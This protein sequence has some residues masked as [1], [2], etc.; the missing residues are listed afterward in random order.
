VKYN[1]NRYGELIQ[2][3]DG[4]VSCTWGLS[5]NQYISVVDN[6]DFKNVKN[7]HG[8]FQ[9]ARLQTFQNTTFP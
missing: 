3:D 4:L 8:F 2:F 5:R 7:L 6:F 1:G 9:Y